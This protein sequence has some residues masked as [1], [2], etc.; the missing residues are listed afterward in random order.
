MK[1]KTAS[2]NILPH[3]KEFECNVHTGESTQR[4][5]I[6]VTKNKLHLLGVHLVAVKK[7]LMSSVKVKLEVKESVQPVYCPKRSVAY[8]M[9][10]SLKKLKIIIPVECS[11][12]Q[13]SSSTKLRAPFEF[14]ETIPKDW[15][16][17]SNQSSTHLQCSTTSLSL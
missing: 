17:F 13:S 11:K 9:L 7:P 5:L 3:D 1:A 8:E 10:N 14:A 2:D 16:L 4:S 6:H 15:T 12:L